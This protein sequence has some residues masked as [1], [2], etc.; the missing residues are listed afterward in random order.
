MKPTKAEDL[1]VL[2]WQNMMMRCYNP[3]NKKFRLYG[4]RG[5][6]VCDRWHEFFAFYADTGDAPPGMSLDRKNNDGDYTPDN[7]RWATHSQQMLNRRKY[8]FSKRKSDAGVKIIGPNNTE[9]TLHQAAEL[10]GE[11][12]ITTRSRLRKR[13]DRHPEIKTITLGELKAKS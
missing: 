12:Y 8:T 11:K 13:K 10:L 1:A 3:K 4:G 9:I 6:K 7:W 5:I 2:R